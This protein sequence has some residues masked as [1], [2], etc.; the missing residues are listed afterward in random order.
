MLLL[1]LETCRRG[2]SPTHF[3][4]TLFPETYRPKIDVIFDGIE[5]DIFQ[6]RQDVPRQIGDRAI[7]PTTRV[8]TYV[9][10]GFEAMRGFDIF[11]RVAKRIYEQFPDVVFA[12]V[13]SDRICY[14]GDEKHIEHKTF[15]EHVMAQAGYDREQVHLHGP[16][17]GLEAGGF[18]EHQRPASLFHRPVRLELVDGGCAAHA[19]APCSRRTPSRC[20]R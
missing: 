20:A 4:Q 18:V 6:R 8:V 7:P 13:G 12:V 2:Y 11:M 3:Q 9:S 19:A 1:D 10:R 14:G 17:A 15:R 5:T 16:A